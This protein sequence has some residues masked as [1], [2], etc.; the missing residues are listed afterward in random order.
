MKQVR[1]NRINLPIVERNGQRVLTTAQLAECYGTDSKIIANNFNRNRERYE[2]SKHYV[3]LIGAE[4]QNFKTIH[5]FDE[6]FKHSSKVYLWTERGALLH[7]KSLNTDE[8]WKVYDLLVEH[9]F[10]TRD[11]ANLPQN[12]M[13]FEII[14][15]EMA[16]HILTQNNT[17]NRKINQACVRRYAS[18]ML[19]GNFS[20]NG[21]TIRFYEDGT[22]ADGQH[23][24]L[25]CVLSNVPL[26]TYVV[27][28]LKKEV[29]PTI[30][31][32]KQRNMVET[33]N[34]IGCHVNK[35]LVPA[36]NLYFNNR[37]QMTANQVQTIWECFEDR[38][39]AL[40]VILKGSHHDHI[41]S[42][43]DVRAYMI[44]LMLAEGWSDDDV[45][46]MVTGLKSKPNC[47]SNFDYTC[48]NF[49]QWYDKYIHNKIT[50]SKKFAETP[51]S[52][53][54][55]EGLCVVSDSFVNDTVYN[56]FMNKKLPRAKKI[57][58]V[59]K[60]L[61]GE[62]FDLTERKEFIVKKTTST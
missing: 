46:A 5:Q 31:C 6:Q 48:Y 37:T 24:L 56:K 1:I 47:V 53:M 4:L 39:S 20:V 60:R 49:R 8:A 25:A 36:M 62:H 40:C 9:Y 57:M 58:E 23:R 12:Y 22:L 19:M 51:K 14:S 52:L 38:L 44:H 27:R 41:L 11:Y 59:G 34:M 18:D 30:D 55:I 61:A 43:K 15:P 35:M 50:D 28:G 2:E 3:C 32:G 26:Q 33:L 17:N 13:T 29:L 16:A 42:Q 7:A 10:R 45:Q 54:T 21:D